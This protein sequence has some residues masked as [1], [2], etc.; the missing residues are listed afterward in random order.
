MACFR[1][2]SEGVAGSNDLPSVR[3]ISKLI[4]T[5]AQAEKLDALVSEVQEELMHKQAHDLTD[6]AALGMQIR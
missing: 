1:P 4:A 3:L 5:S 2:P 6:P